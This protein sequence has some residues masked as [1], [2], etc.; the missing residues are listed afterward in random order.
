MQKKTCEE[1]STKKLTLASIEQTA[2]FALFI[3]SQV[4]RVRVLN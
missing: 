2:R 4:I 1:Q 3:T